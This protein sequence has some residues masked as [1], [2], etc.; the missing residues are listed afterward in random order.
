[1]DVGSVML[2]DNPPFS[3]PG[4]IRA[5]AKERTLFKI[6]LVFA[7]L[8]WLLLTVV[9][10]GIVWLILPLMYVFGLAAHSYFISN[11]QGNGVHV[12]AAQF[13]Q[14]HERFQACCRAVGLEREPEFYLMS[15]NGVL[16]AFA[17]RFLRRYYVVLLSDVVDALED[18][19]DALNFYIGHEL[20]HIARKHLARHWWISVVT[21]T[22][23]LGAAYARAREYT[24]DQYGLACCKDSASAMRALAVLAAG[25][26]RW[27][28]VNLEAYIAQAERSGGFWMSLNELT[29]DYP[30]LCKR[31]ARV[32]RGDAAQFPRRHG[33]AWALAALVPNT[34]F[35]VIGGLILYI[36]VGSIGAGVAIPAYK[37]YVEKARVAQQRLAYDAAYASGAA[38]ADKVGHF[39]VEHQR[40]PLTAR[41]AGFA[42]GAR[43]DIDAGDGRL[44]VPLAAPLQHLALYFTPS[45]G[46][47][48]V[49]W[50]CSADAGAPAEAL[51]P[52]CRP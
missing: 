12:G 45:M 1:M 25:G 30:W 8:F 39:L 21:L 23:L 27:K 29:A 46:G 16:N 28:S 14:L 44:S 50:V 6:L 24:C 3:S 20:G 34:G 52:E 32:Q 31:V 38:A 11:L 48:A 15:G 37:A 22:P 47:A 7:A 26:Q 49:T 42:A 2:R 9:T 33:M 5:Y 36:Y 40:L 43:I 19:Q 51:P 41:E 13:P 18:D 10:V 35:G 17:T 4:K